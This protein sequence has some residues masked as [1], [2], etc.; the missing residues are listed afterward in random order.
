MDTESMFDTRSS[1]LNRVDTINERRTESYILFRN[2][3]F[4]GDTDKVTNAG[5]DYLN[6]LSAFYRVVLD[7]SDG[8]D[9]YSIEEKLEKAENKLV[10]MRP[11]PGEMES[12]NDREKFKE[13][14]ELLTDAEDEIN[15]FRRDVGLSISKTDKTEEG[16][17]L[18]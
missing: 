5:I 14:E 7:H 17:E 6:M 16:T 3:I 1:D 18:L 12:F 4:S 15:E 13:L 10:D 11:E 8:G 2:A 9:D